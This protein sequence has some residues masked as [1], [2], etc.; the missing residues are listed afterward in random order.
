MMNQSPEILKE[1]EEFWSACVSKVESFPKDRFSI[2][3]IT[4]G[5]NEEFSNLD[6]TFKY[7]RNN[8]F[9]FAIVDWIYPM[10]NGWG[11]AP[12]EITPMKLIHAETDEKLK[13]WILNELIDKTIRVLFT[14]KYPNG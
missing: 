10:I 2:T 3:V 4:D 7:I 1:R 14:E 13:E 6:E 12:T 5:E 9:K 8:S 11:H